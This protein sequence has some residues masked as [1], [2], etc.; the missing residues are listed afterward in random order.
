MFLTE[1]KVASWVK[2]KDGLLISRSIL[3]VD[4]FDFHNIKTAKYACITGYKQIIDMFFNKYIDYFKKGVILIIIESDI[5]EIPKHFLQH[6]NLIH[7]FTWN[8]PFHHDKLSSLPIGLNYN[9]QYIVLDNWLNQ[10]KK[11]N[12]TKLLCFNCSLNTDNS[13]QQLLIKAKKDWQDF[14]TLLDYVPCLNN[15]MLRSYIEG[16]INVTV[17]NPKCYDDW[18]DFKFVLSPRGAGIDCH[19]TWEVL[20]IGRIPIVLSSSIDKLYKDLPVV[21]IKDWSEINKNFLEEQYELYLQNMKN[22]KYNMEKLHLNYWVNKFEKK[23]NVKIP[24]IHFITYGNH[25]FEEAKNR[26]LKEADIFGVFQNIKGYGP[27]D[28]PEDFKNT[29]KEILDMPRGGGYWIWRPIIINQALEKIEE[30]DFL[31]Y[32][33]AGCMLNVQG[34]RRFYEYIRLLNNSKY[35]ILSFQM[36]GN[37]S[38]GSLSVE[39]EWTT[40][41]IFDLFGISLYSPIATSGQYLGGVLVMKKNKHLLDYMKVYTHTVL[42]NVELC[43]DKF[44]KNQPCKDFK[45]N[46]H[47]QSITSVLRKKMGS[48]VIEK[49]ESWMVPFGKDE[50]LNY[51]FWATRRRN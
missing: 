36:T 2:S 26:L 32:L 6:I 13:R 14:C 29:Y 5:I 25:V 35:G 31:V 9:R 48:F 41:E 51:P 20:A 4:N 37:N 43:T 15:Y 7:C 42:N 40:K 24:K 49:D 47:E 22:N 11:K 45:D 8:K 39:R 16:Q 3:N 30:N 10:H 21:I 19:R 34:K 12:P 50:S 17:T 46:R 38:P 23:I 28:L 33:D 44:N 27:Q 1:D 18:S